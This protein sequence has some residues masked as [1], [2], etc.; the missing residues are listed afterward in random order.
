M[1]GKN[2]GKQEYNLQSRFHSG[3]MTLVGDDVMGKVWSQFLVLEAH[4]Q[5]YT[6][7]GTLSPRKQYDPGVSG[8]K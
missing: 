4:R 7:A 6:S 8:G 3:V 1:R 5:L 2:R